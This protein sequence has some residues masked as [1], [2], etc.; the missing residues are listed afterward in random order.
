MHVNMLIVNENCS[1]GCTVVYL[2][3]E[4]S[5]DATA[6]IHF[7]KKPP[8]VLKIRPSLTVIF[9]CEKLAVTPFTL[10]KYI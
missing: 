7:S 6:K 9:I 4:Q 2:G 10:S 3:V 1:K 8:G 5:A